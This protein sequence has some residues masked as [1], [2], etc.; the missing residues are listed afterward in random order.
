MKSTK[1]NKSPKSFENPYRAGG[2]YHAVVETLRKLGTGRMHPA[3]K[4]VAEYRKLIGAAEW[5]AFAAKPSRNEET[6]K[7]ADQRVI[8]NC[9]VVARL[10]YG[11]P[12][13]EI[14]HEVRKARGEDGYQFGIFAIKSAKGAKPKAKAAK[15]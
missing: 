13:R 6:G 7:A 3:A 12:L 11:A 14:G 1:S 4:V 9:I 8:Q 2:S 10:D 15:P 5:K